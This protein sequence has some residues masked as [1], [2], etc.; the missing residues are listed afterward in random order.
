MIYLTGEN[1]FTFNSGTEFSQFKRLQAFNEHGWPTKLL[2]RNY[3]RMLAKDIVAH[4][5]E[6]SRSGCLATIMRASILSRSS[7]LVII[8]KV[9]DFPWK[10][11]TFLTIIS[12]RI[13]LLKRLQ[14]CQAV[15]RD[16]TGAHTNREVLLDAARRITLL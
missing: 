15:N 16:R 2:L 6:S 11:Q 4:G 14:A 8:H 1:V 7:T 13:S 3:N 5:L 9:N 10:Y 12:L